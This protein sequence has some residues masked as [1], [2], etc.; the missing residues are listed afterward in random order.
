M[1]R[2][3]LGFFILIGIVSVMLA[4]LIYKTLVSSGLLGVNWAVAAAYICGTIFGFF[5]NR[6]WAFQDRRLI[7]WRK[8]TYYVVL[9]SCTLVVNIYAN[10]IML[11]L[12]HGIY[13]YI[14][15]SFLVAISISTILNFIGLKYLVFNKDSSLCAD[16]RKLMSFLT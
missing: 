13:G 5:A 1:I 12:I 4:Y 7:T 16:M 2:R 15:I 3:E 9:Y 8:A 11:K 6:R 14:L 10:S